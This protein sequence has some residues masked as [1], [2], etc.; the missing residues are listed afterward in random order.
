MYYRAVQTIET[1]NRLNAIQYT[2]SLI[3]DAVHLESRL[4]L[5]RRTTR[6][7]YITD[8][9]LSYSR[10]DKRDYGVKEEPDIDID[11]LAEAVIQAR[12]SIV[13]KKWK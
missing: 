9:K 6:H 3:D 11:V 5:E 4:V 7:K 2:F 8:L 13:F 12:K 10:I 1:S